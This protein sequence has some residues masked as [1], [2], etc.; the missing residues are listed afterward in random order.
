MVVRVTALDIQVSLR[1]LMAILEDSM[2]SMK[3]L[4]NLE[5]KSW[6]ALSTVWQAGYVHLTPL[7]GGGGSEKGP[8]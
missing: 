2:M 1:Y 6:V 5:W 7:Q 8:F 3:T 4:Y